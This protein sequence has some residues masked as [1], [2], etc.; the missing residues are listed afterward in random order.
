MQTLSSFNLRRQVSPLTESQLRSLA[1][2]VFADTAHARTSAKYRFYPTSAVVDEL[3]RVGWLPS[4][5]MQQ[6]IRT[7]DRAGFQKHLIR[8]RQVAHFGTPAVRDMVVPEI[9]LINSHDG[10]SAYALHAGLYRCVCANGLMIA[11]STISAIKIRHTGFHPE[12]VVDASRR[13]ADEMPKA[14]EQVELMK[15]RKLS[16][17]ESRALAIGATVLRWEDV[18]TAPIRP[19]MLLRD[20]RSEDIGDDLWRTMNRVQENVIRGGQRDYSRRRDD[21]R[22]HGRTREV[23]GI[24]QTSGINR[25]LWAMAEALRSG[26]IPQQAPTA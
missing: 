8:F 18:T 21:G 15:A 20:H 26:N 12:M 11:D 17:V 16:P 19:E 24:D 5:V 14:V 13:L 4:A 23:K 9:V 7:E 3:S 10:S 2:S 25:A 22:R 6:T 1:P